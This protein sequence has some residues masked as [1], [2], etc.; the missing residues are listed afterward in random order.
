MPE[1]TSDP[2]ERTISESVGY[3]RAIVDE[4]HSRSSIPTTIRGYTPFSGGDVYEN[5]QVAV[6]SDAAGTPMEAYPMHASTVVSMG[7]DT[8]VS[9]PVDGPSPADPLPW[10]DFPERNRFDFGLNGVYSGNQ[11]SEIRAAFRVCLGWIRDRFH[12]EYK[13]NVS[14]PVSVADNR[15]ENPDFRIALNVLRE[16]AA[17]E[18]KSYAKS[19][20]NHRQAAYY[21]LVKA[22]FPAGKSAK[23]PVEDSAPV[24]GNEIT[25]L[26]AARDHLNR[27]IEAREPK[28]LSDKALNEIF[29]TFTN[30]R[31]PVDT[32]VVDPIMRCPSPPEAVSVT[33]SASPW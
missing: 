28:R 13:I 20:G 21:Y 22:L 31:V 15:V 14:W 30:S 24:D 12:L 5:R 29:S 26:K 23:W 16:P 25:L 7:A 19:F 17:P 32:R 11:V 9:T 18:P 8:A 33:A 2:V 27:E 4:R 1:T 6:E 3:L 10:G